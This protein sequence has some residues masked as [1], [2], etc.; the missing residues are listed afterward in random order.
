M[1]LWTRPL[2]ITEWDKNS[3]KETSGGHLL[4]AFAHRQNQH[5]L[6]TLIDAYLTCPWR[7]PMTETLKALQAICLSVVMIHVIRK[8]YLISVLN[9]PSC[10]SNPFIQ[11][12]SSLGRENWLFCSSF[13][14]HFTFL[15]IITMSSFFVAFFFPWSIHSSTLFQF[16]LPRFL[17]WVFFESAFVHILNR[18]YKGI[19]PVLV[20]IRS[21]FQGFGIRKVATGAASVR[22]QGPGLCWTQLFPAGSVTEQ[23]G[24]SAGSISQAD[25]ALGKE[26]LMKSKTTQQQGVRGEKKRKRKRA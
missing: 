26:Y 24:D 5:Y 14:K 22:G 10:N 1:Y 6:S 15:Q 4:C 16:L 8:F 19:L 17:V 21:R 18:N 3:L 9:L 2:P 12:P 20:Y 25:G 23:P 13:Q 7:F 11:F